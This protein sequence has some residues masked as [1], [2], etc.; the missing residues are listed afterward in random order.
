[1]NVS[2]LIEHLKQFDPNLLVFD[3]NW[4][5]MVECHIVRDF[6]LGDYANLDC[7]YLPKAL[8]LSND[9]NM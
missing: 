6:P 1:M 7:E 5:P 8:I 2:E 9:P 3:A 4:E